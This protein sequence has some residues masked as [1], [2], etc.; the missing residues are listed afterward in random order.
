MNITSVHFPQSPLA[1]PTWLYF[2]LT[3]ITV[4]SIKIL[5][6]LLGV[7]L[8]SWVYKVTKRFSYTWIKFPH[9]QVSHGAPPESD[10]NLLNSSWMTINDKYVLSLTF[11]VLYNMELDGFHYR[12]ESKLLIREFLLKRGKDVNCQN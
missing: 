2:T 6:R 3:V 10:G 9:D 4:D 5:K 7:S 8:S 11:L 1:S 12:R